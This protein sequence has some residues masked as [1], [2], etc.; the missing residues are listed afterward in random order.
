VLWN[1]LPNHFRTEPSTNKF[2]KHLLQ[3]F[4]YPKK[5]FSPTFVTRAAEITFV[6][7]RMGFSNLNYH[8][9]SKRCIASPLC[10]CGQVETVDHFLLECSLYQRERT[11]LTAQIDLEEPLTGKIL[12]FGSPSHNK[13]INE[14]I[15]NATQLYIIACNRFQ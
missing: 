14:N 12:L 11:Q 2:K 8:L 7:M 3:R 5:L 9:Y 1:T 13:S 10:V 15:V 4:P 6:Q